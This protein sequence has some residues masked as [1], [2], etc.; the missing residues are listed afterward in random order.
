M[1]FKSIEKKENTAKKKFL[2]R[3]TTNIHINMKKIW[4]F[5]LQSLDQSQKN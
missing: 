4:L 3:K 1:N 5:V 2:K